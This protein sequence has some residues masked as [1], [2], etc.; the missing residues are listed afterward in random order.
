VSEDDDNES[1]ADSSRDMSPSRVKLYNRMAKMGQAVIPGTQ[2]QTS[3]PSAVTEDSQNGS[4][5]NQSNHSAHPQD[6][7]T[8]SQPGGGSGAMMQP[9]QLALFNAQ[10]AA[11]QNFMATGGASMFNPNPMMGGMPGYPG[12]SYPQPAPQ[13]VYQPPPPQLAHSDQSNSS[14]QMVLLESKQLQTDVR[15]HVINMSGKVDD[16]QKKVDTLCSKES[17]FNSAS[18]VTMEAAV[19]MQIISRVI[20]VHSHL[21]IHPRWTNCARRSRPLTPPRK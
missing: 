10:T 13:P 14:M 7:G 11:A 8:M 9:Q 5:S 19:L 15:G 17:P 2:R 16:I 18:Q 12:Y 21:L 6:L 1:Q 20:Q 4:T 3:S